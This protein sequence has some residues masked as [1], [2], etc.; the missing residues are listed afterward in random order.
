[1]PNIVINADRLLNCIRNQPI[2]VLPLTDTSRSTWSTTPGKTISRTCLF[3]SHFSW[4]MSNALHFHWRG[5][6][7]LFFSLLIS[8]ETKGGDINKLC[9]FVGLLTLGI[10]FLSLSSASISLCVLYI[11]IGSTTSTMTVMDSPLR[12]TTTTTTIIMTI[13]TPLPHPLLHPTAR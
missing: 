10:F 4:T 6:G 11:S 13:T 2:L 12:L 7:I 3:S 5:L 9:P 8:R 1:M